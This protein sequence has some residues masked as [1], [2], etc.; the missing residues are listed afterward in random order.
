MIRFA[1][2]FFGLSGF[3]ICMQTPVAAEEGFA[4]GFKAALS[5]G[6]PAAAASLAEGQLA[7]NPDDRTAR[8][9]LGTAQFL[10]AVEALGQ[11]L[12]RHGFNTDQFA[13]SLTMFTGRLSVPI[14]PNPAPEPVTFAALQR[15]LSDFA[16]RLVQAEATL[17]A[18]PPG[19]VTLPLDLAAIRLDLNADGTVTDAEALGPLIRV[20]L[21]VSFPNGQ[22]TFNFDESDVFWLRAYCHLLAGITD[23]LLAHDWSEA[24]DKTLHDLFPQAALTSAPLGEQLADQIARWG[25]GTEPEDFYDT[26]GYW[27]EDLSDPL[28]QEW[29]QSEQGL[30]WQDAQRTYYALFGSS[31][32]DAVAF[33]HLAHWK[34]IAPERMQS[35]R[36]HL[37]QMIAMSRANW[38]SILAETDDTFEWLPGPQQQSWVPRMV[39]RRSTVDGWHRFL[40]Q[41][42]G[43]LEGRLLMPHWRFDRDRGINVRRMFEEPRTFDPVMLLQGVD[44]LPY[45]EAG[46]MADDATASTAFRILDE[47]FLAYFIWFN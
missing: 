22:S 14:P 17:A 40:D 38:A 44:A 37:L 13:Y 8:F 19:P 24:L 28:Y 31:I 12:Y 26:H 36:N 34:V 30:K 29:I 6:P 32:A 25:N 3:L 46:A 27:T 21:R 18:V 4:E 23:A 1:R 7:L 43:V 16:D 10:S 41:F 15:V 42:E 2:L 5:K 39:V 33:V 45:L 47:G 20:S 9:A 35:S 11:D